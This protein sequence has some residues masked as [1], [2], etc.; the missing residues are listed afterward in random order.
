MI[1]RTKRNTAALFRPRRIISEKKW[2]DGTGGRKIAAERAANLKR[3]LNWRVPREYFRRHQSSFSSPAVGDSSHCFDLGWE[4][5]VGE[6]TKAR[7]RTGITRHHCF[8]GYRI[9]DTLSTREARN[10]RFYGKAMT[11]PMWGRNLNFTINFRKIAI[12]FS[13]NC[14]ELFNLTKPR[15]QTENYIIMGKCKTHA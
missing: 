1:Y 4:R 8:E 6:N 11:S 5:E 9:C 15:K 13:E 7:L 3:R 12:E 14:V 10:F 2:E